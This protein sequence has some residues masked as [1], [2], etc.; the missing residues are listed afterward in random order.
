MLAG[1]LTDDEHLA[2]VLGKTEGIRASGGDSD[3][4]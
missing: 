3:S 1:G 2:Q 4:Q